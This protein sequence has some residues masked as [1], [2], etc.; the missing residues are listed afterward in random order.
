MMFS[1]VRR[2]MD[3]WRFWRGCGSALTDANAECG[4]YTGLCPGAAAIALLVTYSEA[5]E[6]EGPAAASWAQVG[7]VETVMGVLHPGVLDIPGIYSQFR[8]SHNESVVVLCRRLRLY[9]FQW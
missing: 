6:S 5:S 2:V 9:I 4:C 7:P 1:T 3:T 8:C